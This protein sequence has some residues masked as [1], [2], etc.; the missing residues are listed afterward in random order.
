MT[1]PAPKNFK[2]V[3]ALTVA[4]LLSACAVGPDYQRPSAPEPVA[5]KEAPQSGAQW[6][7]AAP[8]DTLDRGPWWELFGDPVLN[9]LVAQVEVS[10]QNVAA[11]AA[12]YEQSR[13][14]VTQQR[15]SLF[16]FVGLN[17]SE[18]RIG[19]PAN[20]RA[21]NAAALGLQASWEP[22]I[23]GELRRGVEGAQANAQASEAS[24]AAA[25]LSAQGALATNYFL[26]R[27]ADIEIGLLQEAVTAYERA[28]KITQNS[29]D[30]G[31]SA[32][33]DVLQ[34]RTQLASTRAN[35]VSVQGQR[36]QLEHAIAVLIGKAPTDFTL[37]P[38]ANWKGAVPA[39]PLG[40]P[41]TLLQ[42]RPDIAQSERSVAAANAQIGVQMAGYYPSFTLTGAYGSAAVRTR[43]LFDASAILWSIGLSA[44][45]TL[46]DAG[47]T[48]ARVAQAEAARSGA[49]AQ[50]RQTV[51][52]AFQS[53]EDQLSLARSLAEQAEFRR[54]ASEAANLTE[55]QILNQYKEG[56]VAYTDVVV[57][58]AAALNARQVLSQ[59]AASRLTNAVALIQSLGGGWQAQQLEHSAD[60]AP[61]AAPKP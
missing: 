40:V 23:W 27:D 48:K 59:L 24:L 39:V 5:F 33:T 29:Y 52:S 18:K 21:L 54:E 44:A 55:T 2:T 11:A 28:L 10:N 26:L 3:A 25:R 35:L 22:D 34:A 9:Q 8:A 6:F 31:I 20:G 49:V 45:Q 58:Q 13:A 43:D 16:P 17:A 7:P 30:A 37:E 1:S 4:M 51:L 61:L 38:V 41:S 53:V 19:G 50:Y 60:A 36:P 42:R 32:K 57:A 12:A 14:L 56:Q 47:A 46:F 15:S